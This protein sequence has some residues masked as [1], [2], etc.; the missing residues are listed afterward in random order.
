VVDP[1]HSPCLAVTAAARVDQYPLPYFYRWCARADIGDSAGGGGVTHRAPC[2][3][4][5][6]LVR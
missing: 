3:G 5:V 4:E 6:A 1:S 2:A